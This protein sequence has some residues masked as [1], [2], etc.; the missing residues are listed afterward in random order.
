[1]RKMWREM[2]IGF[3]DWARYKNR[4]CAV[5][6]AQ[7]PDNAKSNSSINEV[8]RETEFADR[9]T[10][11]DTISSL[12]IRLLHQDDNFALPDFSMLFLRARM[13][14]TGVSGTGFHS[15][16]IP[17]KDSESST[18]K[19]AVHIASTQKKNIRPS[20]RSRKTGKPLS[21]R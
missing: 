5:T 17:A 7:S 18:Q 3:S 12:A 19:S 1:M 16:R 20:L 21:A 4:D 9:R 11:L 13:V 8:D 10:F 6:I 15:G 14:G 2:R